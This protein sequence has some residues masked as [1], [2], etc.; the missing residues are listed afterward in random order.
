MC[1]AEKVVKAY[2]ELAGDLHVVAMERPGTSNGLGLSLAGNRDL[3][4]MSVFIAGIRPTG[5]IGQDGRVH[6]GDEILEVSYLVT[7][8][9][10]IVS[11]VVG[12]NRVV[13]PDFVV[14]TACRTNCK[15]WV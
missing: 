7:S 5:A 11:W 10:A 8:W 3:S 9:C 6:V 13:L 1:V 12:R 15:V 14:I 4:T 2:G